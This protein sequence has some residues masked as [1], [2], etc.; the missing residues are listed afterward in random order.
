MRRATVGRPRG[1]SRAGWR[2]GDA[3]LR[4]GDELISVGKVAVQG[5]DMKSVNA[6]IRAQTRARGVVSLCFR[7]VG[8]V[9]EEA[10]G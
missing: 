9:E 2:R 6:T 1:A 5:C 7:R 10:E 8:D 3:E 4:I